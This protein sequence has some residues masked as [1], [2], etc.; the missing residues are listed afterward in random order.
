MRERTKVKLVG[1][2]LTALKLS[3]CQ[4]KKMKAMETRTPFIYIYHND[5]SIVHFTTYETVFH[6]MEMCCI[7]TVLYCLENAGT[8]QH[9]HFL[10]FSYLVN[11]ITFYQTLARTLDN[12][13]LF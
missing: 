13:F 11:Q 12:C 4:H 9:Q 2:I 7:T 3:R 8:S 1:L 10:S 5:I 6:C